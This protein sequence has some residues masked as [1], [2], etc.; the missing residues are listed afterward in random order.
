MNSSQF[1]YSN[2]SVAPVLL[3]D[4][5][6]SRVV[7]PGSK[8]HAASLVSCM[9]CHS[10]PAPLGHETLRT[11]GTSGVLDDAPEEVNCADCHYGGG[12][13][14]DLGRDGQQMRNL[15][16]GGFGITAG[17]T[18][19]RNDT[20][21]A[22]AHNAW[23]AADN[24]VSRFAYGANNDACIACHTHV[25]V[26]IQFKKA[27]KIKLT[28]YELGSGNYSIGAASTEGDVTIDTYGNASGETW[29][30]GD[31]VIYWNGSVPLYIDGNKSQQIQFPL[32]GTSEDSK[33]ALL[34]Q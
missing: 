28:A 3:F 4:G 2:P 26:D 30:V 27:Y 21:E 14:S 16:A 32:T 34:G 1:N 15:W 17:K 8:Y 7:N 9:E 24:G 25:P 18:H 20:G 10:G 11:M 5:L 12:N 22:E 6:G 29:A 31:K 19:S 13:P 33:E 23:V